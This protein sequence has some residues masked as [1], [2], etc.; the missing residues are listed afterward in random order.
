MRWKRLEGDE[1]LPLEVVFSRENQMNQTSYPFWRKSN[2]ARQFVSL[3]AVL[4]GEDQMKQTS[5]RN[6][7]YFLKKIK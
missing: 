4:S 6:W 1:F 3:E 5:L 7:K 2:E